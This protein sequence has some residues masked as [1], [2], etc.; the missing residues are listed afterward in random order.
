VLSPNS[1]TPTFN[2]RLSLTQD[3]VCAL[4]RGYCR[5]VGVPEFGL[6][7]ALQLETGSSPQEKPTSDDLRARLD[8]LNE[9]NRSLKRSLTDA[10]TNLALQRSEVAS[11]KAQCEEKCYELAK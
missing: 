4:F 5:K 6:Y 9:E 8:E 1:I 7:C 10:Q 11:L 2:H 3:K